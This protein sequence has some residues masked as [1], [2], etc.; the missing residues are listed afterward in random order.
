MFVPS[1]PQH[2]E[3]LLRS[4]KELSSKT[5]QVIALKNLFGVPKGA[6]KYYEA[7]D[8][9]S[10]PKPLPGSS[11]KPENRIFFH[12][13]QSTHKYLNGHA[14]NLMTERLVESF[15]KQL[16]QAQDITEEWTDM[17]DFWLWFRGNMFQA[18]VEA[19]FGKHM[20]RLNPSLV[21]DFWEYDRQGLSILKGL[22]RWMNPS[23]YAIRDKVMNSIKKWHKFASD[24]VD[25]TKVAANDP[26]WDEYW[27]AK[28]FKA[29]Q[30]YM[31]AMHFL[32]DDAKAGE[33]LGFMFASNAN[34]IPAAGWMALHTFLDPA[35]L[36]RAR[37]DVEDSLQ[38]SSDAGAPETLNIPKLC[39]KPLLQS[40][41]AEALRLNTGIVVGRTPFNGPL[42]VGEWLFPKGQMILLSSRTAAMNA[43]IW[44]T[45]TTDEPHP[46]DTF[47]ADRFVVYPD[48]PQSGPLKNPA[49][50]AE[51]LE[52]PEYSMRGLSGA[53]F[54]Y[55]GGLGMCPG[56]HFAKQEVIAGMAVLVASFDIELK[57][58]N[59]FVP[60]ADMNYFPVSSSLQSVGS[61]LI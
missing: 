45:G 49:P 29:R 30:E 25:A 40:M 52:A 13:H 4:S 47:W 1:A 42:R 6:L 27:G 50:Q 3:I 15:S 18:S 53:W 34:A 26:E 32:D 16:R 58:P 9:G 41:Y 51:K 36:E 54:P 43:E 31:A 24:H 61:M 56:R 2:F 5:N 55:G 48:R 28:V 7:D 19:L 46:L 10:Q 57:V 60:Q 33:D 20:L 11:I 59:G 22:P 8:S 12:Q 35:L 14:L 37:K 38:P 23:G 17:P 21:D 39:S 44:N